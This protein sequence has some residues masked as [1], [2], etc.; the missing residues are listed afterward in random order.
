MFVAAL[1]IAVLATKASAQTSKVDATPPPTV[2]TTTMTQTGAEFDR[3]RFDALRAEGFEALYNLDYERARQ[4]FKE[5]MRFFPDHPAGSQFLAVSIWLKTLNESRRLQA[6][7]Y[8]TD[9]FYAEKEDKADPK[10]LAEF[11]DLTRQTKTLAEARLRRDP[12]DAEALYFLGASEALKAAFAG[13]VERSFMSALHNG[14]DAVDHQREVLKLDPNF[15]DAE[16]SIGMYDYVAGTLPLPVKLMAAI[17][18]VRGSRK[19]GLATLERVAREGVWA[20]DDA[21]VMLIALYKR[22]RRFAD[23]YTMANALGLK[24]P[25]NYLF[26]ME[27]ADALVSQAAVERAI[28]PSAARKSETQAFAIFDTLLQ[29]EEHPS[30]TSRQQNATTAATAAAATSNAARAPLDLVH[31][32]YGEALFV[33][34]QTERAAKELL[35]AA[36]LP[37]AEATLATRARLRAAQALDASGK[38]ADALVQYNAVLARPNVFDSH[39]AAQ[40]GLK[41]PYKVSSK[42]SEASSQQTQA[43]DATTEAKKP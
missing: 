29:R 36:T 35:A 32:S 20:R 10:I 6:A 5:M 31:Y 13:M 21:S 34:G 24:Y 30:S 2:A 8:N 12:K 41:E 14:S 33:A 38:R 7:L 25:R 22:E 9:D 43:E 4:H 17:G 23:A 27:A 39:E 3:K 28:D 11:R 26:K 19:R 15:H 1:L 18:G 16:V 40:R 37:N 42:T